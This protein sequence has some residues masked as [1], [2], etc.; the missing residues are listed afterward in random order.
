MTQPCLVLVKRAL[1]LASSGT[2][3]QKASSCC[4]SLSCEIYS[5]EQDMANT[6]F[7]CQAHHGISFMSCS[8]MPVAVA[9]VK[10]NAEIAAEAA[11]STRAT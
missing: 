8:V 2:A 4:F 9:N 10:D 3:S 1:M 7:E 11:V 5:P 6:A